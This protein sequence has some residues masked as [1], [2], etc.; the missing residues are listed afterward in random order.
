[1]WV[2]S[3]NKISF[4]DTDVRAVNYNAYFFYT[5]ESKQI[6]SNWH[7]VGHILPR[8]SIVN[9]FDNYTTTELLDKLHLMYGDDFIHYLKGNFVI[10]HLHDKGFKIY[11]DRFG[12]KKFFYRHNGEEFILTDDL[13]EITKRVKP[14]VS[15]ENI[16]VYALTYHFTGGTTAFENVWHNTPG[17]I[18]AF[19]D[20]KLHLGTYWQPSELLGLRKSN[21]PIAEIS[22][23]L[24]KAVDNG[25]NLIGKEKISL[26]LTGGADTRNLLAIF[27]SKGIK[28]HLYTYGNPKSGDCVKASVIAKGLGLEHCI[29]DIQINETNFKN[30]AR[31]IIREGGGLAS[32][33]RVHRL[34]AV[35]IE[36]QFANSMFLGTL[37]GEFIKG[38]SEDDYI[39][40]AI[41]SDCWS[42]QEFTEKQLDEYL[43]RKNISSKYLN[44]T[45]LL[46]FISSEPYIKGSVIERKHNSLS[47]ITAHL[48][49]AQDVNLYNAEME[50]VF[51][52]FLDIDYLELL[53]SSLFTF[54]Q[55]EQIENPFIKRMDNPIY[56]AKFI[57]ATYKPLLKYRYS[58]EHIPSEVLFN[59]YYAAFL[60]IIRQKTSPKYPPNFPLGKW[61]EEFVNRN[62][63]ACNDFEEL[64]NTFD[65]ESLTKELQANKHIPKESYWLK[66]TNPIMMRFIIEEFKA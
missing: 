40:P 51:T 14:N 27:L 19:E 45:F 24:S 11:S 46:N 52:P 26:S 30:Y 62:L 25:L 44:K 33:H 16:A 56:G 10:I 1:M 15:K 29:H 17:Q 43:I 7:F 5:N 35:E 60:K 65:L 31:R 2:L 59:K 57:S 36:R 39:V 37:G 55:K 3:N 12:I 4:N 9:Q 66:F 18:I 13:K 22:A 63:P 64:K 34:M 47:F 50:N 58:G 8:N 42:C 61:M 53:F 54:D 49:D 48:H 21:I 38:V 20:D 32:I 6:I 28:P 41:V 23:A